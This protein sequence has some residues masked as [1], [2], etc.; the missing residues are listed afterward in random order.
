[1]SHMQ[2]F[3]FFHIFKDRCTSVKHDKHSG[4]PSS[5]RNDAVMAKERDLLPAD[6]SLPIRAESK[7]L[8][9]SCVSC[10]AN[11]SKELGTRCVSVKYIPRTGVLSPMCADIF[12]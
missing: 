10:Q 6:Q 3:E 7:E 5:S 8:S 2:I 1:M 12:S 9:I 4:H 11:L